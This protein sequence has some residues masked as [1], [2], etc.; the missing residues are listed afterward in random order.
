M[1]KNLN[2]WRSRRRITAAVASPLQPYI[3]NYRP[4]Q[5]Y[6][7]LSHGTNDTLT[8]SPIAIGT[9]K[10]SNPV[11]VIACNHQ[12]PSSTPKDSRHPT[13]QKSSKER[14]GD[15]LC[16]SRPAHHT[17][18]QPRLFTLATVACS[19]WSKESS[20]SF[21]SLSPVYSA[22]ALQGAG[23]SSLAAVSYTHL[24]LPTKRIV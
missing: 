4:P 6:P 3:D 1:N 14:E 22:S 21:A 12:T 17:V 7:R 23:Q 10:V 8:L 20:H 16:P 15:L 2:I 5:I 18:L 11:K 19:G 9:S 24:T 13:A